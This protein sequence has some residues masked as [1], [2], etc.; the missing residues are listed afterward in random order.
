MARPPEVHFR[1]K[2]KMDKNGNRLIYLEFLYSGLRLFYSFGQ[3]VNLK[4]WNKEKERVKNKLATTEDGK[5]ALND[6]LDKLQQLCDKTFK[7]CLKDGTPNPQT[8]RVALDAFINKNHND[9]PVD[10]KPTLFNLIDR[11][12]AGEIKNRGKE[13][14]INTI[15]TYIT[16]QKHLLEF[17]Q[18]SKIV[19]NFDSITLDFYYQ[20]VTFLKKK[21]I[22][23]NAIGKDISILKVFMG[24]A[25]DLLYTTNMQFRHKKFFV[26][27]EDAENVY[28]T[29]I[30]LL[31]LYHCILDNPIME[32]QRDLFIIGAFTG[33]RLSDFSSIKL[34]NIVEIEGQLFIK[35]ITKK[36]KALVIIPCNPVVI[37]ILKKYE[38]KKNNVPDAVSDQYFNRLL[39]DACKI[40]GLNE[41]GR[42]STIPEQELYKCVSSHTA[43]RSMATN[44]YLQ[45][46]PTIDLM[47]ITGHTTERSFMKYIK[48]SKLDAAKR[49]SEHIKVNWSKKLLRVA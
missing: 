46:F 1:L 7:E 11:F 4:D 36:T 2:P 48:M 32:Q 34:E 26:T 24:E 21:D 14:S 47:K 23:T 25:I 19:L 45:G 49:L 27:R 12:I 41:V 6:L 3:S 9:K 39:K 30:E 8:L 31:Q 37:E 20:Y 40:A 18:K 38:G 17:E 44:Y 16:C 42:L 28:L 5:F 15:K 35:K 33:L 10:D 29:E 13:K 22:G 43:R